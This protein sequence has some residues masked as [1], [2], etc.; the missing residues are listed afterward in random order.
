MGV[1]AAL[2]TAVARQACRNGNSR[3]TA[4]PLA[5]PGSRGSCPQRGT[6]RR[7]AV[8]AAAAG[9][10]G[11]AGSSS[12]AGGGKGP[13]DGQRHGGERERN[14]L[15]AVSSSDR[16]GSEYGE[17]FFQ[18]RL[19]GERTHLDVDTLN[20]QMQITGRQRFRHSM[21]PDEAFGLIF[22]W[23]NVVAETRALQR[24]AWQRVAE[25]EGLPFPSLE[26][27]Q[28]YDVR[29]ERA[30]TDVLMWTRDW[31]RA[32]E[33]AWLVASEYGRL[34]LDLAQPRDGVADWL[35]VGAAVQADGGLLLCPR[36]WAAWS[37]EVFSMRGLGMCLWRPYHWPRPCPCRSRAAD[38]QDACAVRL[39][40]HH[41]PP[42][43]R[44]AAGQ[45]GAAPL[46]HVPCHRCA[47][48]CRDASLAARLPAL[49][50]AGMA[51]SQRG[52][53]A[54]GAATTWVRAGTCAQRGRRSLPPLRP[55]RWPAADDDMETISQRYLSA[56]IKL[57]RPPNQCV[58][59]A[60]CPTSITGAARRGWMG[61]QAG[62]QSS[63][64][65]PGWPQQKRSAAG[66]SRRPAAC[67]PALPRAALPA[68]WL[69]L[70]TTA[71]CGPWRCWAPTRPLTSR[72]PTS[73]AP[74]C[75]SCLC[76]TSGGCRRWC[77]VAGGSLSQSTEG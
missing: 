52:S 57:G 41:G 59:F 11:G 58:V 26:R 13:F 1:A 50:C 28:L 25:A 31:G 69:Q 66:R 20:E 62:R 43:H 8:T 3:R 32:Q 10:G 70:P 63:P 48:A 67:L 6:S 17:G 16:A 33:L 76:T 75:V 19:S 34:L 49:S 71:R 53:L 23:D 45:A 30:A 37:A 55:C 40:H 46:L 65:R 61:G 60:A 22:N 39:G 4:Q 21:R 68:P 7:A 47:V 27:P 38:E 35:Q 9:R 51:A 2:D 18:F 29:P 24:Q 56:A 36:A 77:C 5:P 64:S 12:G 15:N 72:T 74:T 44:R 14:L 73:P 42:H 54:R